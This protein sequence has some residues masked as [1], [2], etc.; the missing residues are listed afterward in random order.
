[1]RNS[2]CE[3]CPHGYFISNGYCVTCPRNSVLN[4]QT[5]TCDCKLGF[6]TNQYGMCTRK[7]GTN[8]VYDEATLQCKCLSGLGRINGACT[9]C[10]DGAKPSA[11]GQSCSQCGVN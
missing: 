1:M 9:V 8:E 7:C 10:P 6:F 2:Q 11:D 3:I 4:Q 5:K